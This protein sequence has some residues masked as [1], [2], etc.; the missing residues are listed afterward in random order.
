[1]SSWNRVQVARHAERP[2][3]V[4]YIETNKIY[5]NEY[6]IQLFS[7]QNFL[8][9]NIYS[10]LL[11]FDSYIDFL[12]NSKNVLIFAK[13]YDIIFINDTFNQ[14]LRKSERLIYY[15]EY[16]DYINNT[17]EDKDNTNELE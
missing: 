5:D 15:K 16:A 12:K 1:M 9:N 10:A 14:K 17:I 8:K 13:F 7:E 2:H 4:D 3:T 11:L 6:S